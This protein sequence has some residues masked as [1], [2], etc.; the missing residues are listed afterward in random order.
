[1]DGYASLTSA[2]VAH[3]FRLIL[4]RPPESEAVIGHYVA[5]GLS[6]PEFVQVLLDSEEV[7]ERYRR[8]LALA[9]LRD[10]T[11]TARWT[12]PGSGCR[13]LLF[14]AYGNG[15]LG[16]AAQAEA[17]AW[18]LRRVLPG[19]V[20]FAACSWERRAPYAFADGAVLPANALL[21]ADLL[22]HGPDAGLVVIG[23]GGLLGAPHFPLHAEAWAEWF[24][25][26]GVKWVLLGLGGSAEAL[27]VPAWR[28]AYRR[29]IEGA[30][31][32]GLRDAETLAFAQAVN[33]SATWFPDP[34]LARALLQDDFSTLTKSGPSRSID[35]V[36]IPRHPNGP[37]DEAANR[38]AL[39]WGDAM[40]RLGHRVVV[41]AMEPVLDGPA[42]AGEEVVFV[43]DWPALMRLCRQTRLVASMR[44][45]GAIAGLAAGCIVHGLLQPKIGDLMDTLG[46]RAW[47]SPHGWPDAPPDWSPATAEAFQAAVVPGLKRLRAQAAQALDHAGRSLQAITP[48]PA[49]AQL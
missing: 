39:A 43:N 45:H 16:D 22:P 11:P 48:G 13:V 12:E 30:A 10:F 27:A 26:Q 1:M 32:V 24:A 20:R 21:R 29:L 23:G 36:I 38:A 25:A 3:Y 9:G 5:M 49:P 2:E 42:L 31:L 8:R 35:T 17:L 37:L 44:L 46:I 6:A 7:A 34:V 4:G 41:A 28:A 47:F 33:E 40:V 18:L 15:N 19:D 14:G